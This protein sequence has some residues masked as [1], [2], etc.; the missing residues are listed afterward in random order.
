MSTLGGREPSHTELVAQRIYSMLSDQPSW[1]NGDPNCRRTF[2]RWAEDKVLD[3]RGLRHAWNA[4]EAGY[5]A[6]EG[7]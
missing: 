2:I 7:F 3:L 1:V 4:F 5:A 6:G